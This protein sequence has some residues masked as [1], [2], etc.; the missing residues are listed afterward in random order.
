MRVPLTSRASSTILYRMR[1]SMT[2]GAMCTLVCV[3]Y[4]SQMTCAARDA[5][6]KLKYGSPQRG[7][8][9]SMDKLRW[10]AFSCRWCAIHGV[11]CMALPQWGKLFALAKGQGLPCGLPER[12]PWP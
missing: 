5:E 9:E 10:C 6:E 12:I 11:N 2:W 3:A 4:T 7:V 8:K 1:D